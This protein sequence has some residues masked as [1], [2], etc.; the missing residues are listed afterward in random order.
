M[1]LLTAGNEECRVMYEGAGV[2]SVMIGHT[3][4]TSGEVQNVMGIICYNIGGIFLTSSC[5][6]KHFFIVRVIKHW[7]RLPREVVESPSLEIIKSCL[8]TVLGTCCR[9]PWV[10]RGVG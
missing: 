8:D 10:G 2:L 4:K 5:I 6:R 3:G 7:H 9:G 1:E